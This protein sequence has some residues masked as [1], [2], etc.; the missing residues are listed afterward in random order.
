MSVHKKPVLLDGAIGTS[1]WAKVEDKLPVWTYNI[2]RPDVV[3]ELCHEY[4]AAGS[5]MILA[6]TFGANRIA[7]ERASDYQVVDV[8]SAAVRIAKKAAEGTD[9]KVC[10]SIGPLSQFMEPYGDLEE[11]EAADIFHEQIDAGMSE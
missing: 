3:E 9:V 11:E 10:L 5:K 6:N 2:T 7:V 4:I 8:V 1:I